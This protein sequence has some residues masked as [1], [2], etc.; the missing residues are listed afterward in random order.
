MKTT[1]DVFVRILRYGMR[2]QVL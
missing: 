1:N 2:S